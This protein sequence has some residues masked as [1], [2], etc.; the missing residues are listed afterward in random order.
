M[1]QH[2]VQPQRAL[3]TI[4]ATGTSVATAVA[5]GDPKMRAIRTRTPRTNAL[6]SARDPL[7]LLAPCIPFLTERMYQN[8]AMGEGFSDEGFRFSDNRSETEE[9]SSLISENRKPKTENLLPSSV[10]LAT[11]QTPTHRCL[12]LTSTSAWRRLKRLCD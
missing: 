6:R 8:L 10:H 3:L 4:S 1:L 9:S 2:F 5:S 11:T 7:S 12:T